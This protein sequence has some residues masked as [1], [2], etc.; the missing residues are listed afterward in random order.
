MFPALLDS[1]AALAATIAILSLLNYQIGALILRAHSRQNFI[2]SDAHAPQGTVKKTPPDRGLN[3]PFLLPLVAI[4]LTLSADRQ[5]REMF[6]GGCLVMLVAG[7]A[8]HITNLLMMRALVRPSAAEG[9]IRYS[10]MYAY[11]GS[12]AQALG[13]AAFSG[14]VA[15]L[16]GSLAFTAGALFLLAMAIEYYRLARRAS[17]KAALSAGAAPLKP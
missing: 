9:R 17:R 13:L 14:T 4:S 2:E 1:P 6:G 5:T 10:T 16:F 7:F 12:G 3:L 11:R 8:L 15:I